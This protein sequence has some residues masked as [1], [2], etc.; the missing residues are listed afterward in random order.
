MNSVRTLP[1]I[2]LFLALLPA[3]ASGI[4]VN[5]ASGPAPSG[6][7]SGVSSNGISLSGAPG[8]GAPGTPGSDPA[9]AGNPEGFGP[10]GDREPAMP[11]TLGSSKVWRFCYGSNF[12]TCTKT[13]P[14]PPIPKITLD[15]DGFFDLSLLVQMYCNQDDQGNPCSGWQ[16]EAAG[17]TV[18]LVFVPQY[19]GT[20]GAQYCDTALK[21]LQSDGSNFAVSQLSA[22]SGMLTFYFMGSDPISDSMGPTVDCSSGLVAFPA[23][24]YNYFSS[25]LT[26][27]D[28]RTMGYFRLSQLQLPPA[29]K[30]APSPSPLP[31]SPTLQ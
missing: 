27:I 5:S 2:L 10:K 23:G 11:K 1:K 25:E 18:R 30:P 13:D 6:S 26:N 3:C 8:S 29:P 31:P 9:A 28:A 24:V 14:P 4:G 20:A 16:S 22:S 15:G 12:S 19:G 7:D 17:S 21:N